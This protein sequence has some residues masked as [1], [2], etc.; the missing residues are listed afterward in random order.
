MEQRIKI[1]RKCHEELA[2]SGM[3]L[4]QW[5]IEICT[6]SSAGFPPIIS[7][8]KEGKGDTLTHYLESKGFVCTT[9]FGFDRLLIR[10]VGILNIWALMSFVKTLT[11]MDQKSKMS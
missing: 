3:I 7:D 8:G 6:C 2:E 10:P 1:C 9:E 5:Y 11:L 4:L